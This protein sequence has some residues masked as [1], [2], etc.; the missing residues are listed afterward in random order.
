[1]TTLAILVHWVHV[2]AGVVWIG[3]QVFLYAALWPALLA[4]PQGEAGAVLQGVMP[5]WAR[6]MGALPPVVGITGILRGT[7]FGP[8]RSWGALATPYGLTFAAATLLVIALVVHGGRTRAAMGARV[9]GPGAFPD[10]ARAFL[11]RQGAI[12]LGLL[13]G[14]FTCMVLMRFG[15]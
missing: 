7:A 3:S 13:G 2:L 14:I 9:F 11:R 6:V 12:T 8:V 10:G 4:R 1:M 5:R 15:M